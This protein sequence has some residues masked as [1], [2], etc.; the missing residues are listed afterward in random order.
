MIFRKTIANTI[1]RNWVV[2]AFAAMLLAGSAWLSSEY[3]HLQKDE[4]RI[5]NELVE[6]RKAELKE[7]V[8]RSIEFIG[9]IRTKTEARARESVRSAVTQAHATATFLWE[10]NRK[11][12]GDAEIRAIILDALRPIR[13]NRGRGYCFAFTGEG[14]QLLNADRPELEGRRLIDLRDSHGAPLFRDMIRIT[15]DEGEGFY[16][17]RWTKPNSSGRDFA[18]ISYVKRFAPYDW[19]I[20]AGEYLDDADLEIREEALGRITSTRFGN[21]GHLFAGT[22]QGASLARV[23]EGG[24]GGESCDRADGLAIRALVDS[25]GEGGRFLP[26]SATEPGGPSITYSRVVPSWG[27]VVGGSVALGDIESRVDQERAD[28]TRRFWWSMAGICG[29]LALLFA[30]AVVVARFNAQRMRRTFERFSAFFRNAAVEDAMIDP[31]GLDFS[32]FKELASLANDMVAARQVTERRAMRLATAVEQAAEDIVITDAA[33]VIEYVNPSFESTTGYSR[34]E[35][36]GRNCRILNGGASDASFYRELWSTIR[37]GSCWKGRFRNRTRDGRLILQDA[38]IS[39]IRD[40]SGGIAGYVSVRRDV[41]EHVELEARLADSQRL[42]AIGL[43]A[44]GIAHDFNNILTAIVGYTEMAIAATPETSP[45]RDNLSQVLLGGKRATELVKQILVFSRRNRQERRPVRIDDLLAESLKLM[46]AAVPSTVRIVSEFAS[47]SQVLANPTQIYQVV[48]N[49]CT[50][51]SAAMDEGGGTLSVRLADV[52]LGERFTAVHPGISPGPYIRLTVEDTGCGMPPELLEHIF[53]PFFTTRAKTGGTGMGLSVVHGIV[54]SL[55]GTIDVSSEVGNGTAFDV[56]LPVAGEQ[57]TVRTVPE[58]APQPGHERILLVDDE[59]AILS[60]VGSRFRDL[61]YKV[62]AC[63][64][65]QAAFERFAASPPDFDILVSDMTM[66]GMT[67]DR[68]ACEARK[69]KPGFPVILCSGYTDRMTP[70][71]ADELGID[72]F[73]AKPVSF[74]VLSAAVRTALDAA[75]RPDGDPSPSGTKT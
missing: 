7:Q 69:V 4:K 45:L 15:R 33:G 35:A 58:T 54:V 46:R 51:A 5:R 11:T 62:T 3:E 63:K 59:E 24:H 34:E 47:T 74:S 17:Y 39:P 20:G 19:V 23:T 68:L 41:T 13:F 44:G 28:M 30:G 70:E 75:S 38:N 25:G 56:Y 48:M 42:E 49:L 8:E 37:S 21:G 1:L 36:V 6:Q 40:G 50:N 18:K 60:L 65:G 10:R 66:P 43:L 16:A 27:W 73:I 52:T 71:K 29:L 57:E 67:G 2:G 55:G 22:M 53:E 64:D 12:K 32:E 14:L 61:G 9:L 26:L 72:A 31:E